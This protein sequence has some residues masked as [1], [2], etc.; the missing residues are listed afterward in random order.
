MTTTSSTN[1]PITL[2]TCFN[3]GNLVDGICHCPSG[4]GGTFCQQKF[5]KLDFSF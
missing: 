2:P 3:G 1:V 4:Y 5:G